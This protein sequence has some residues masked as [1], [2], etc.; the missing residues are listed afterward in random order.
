M[1]YALRGSLGQSRQLC[2]V[3]RLQVERHFGDV[4]ALQG[5]C[6]GRAAAA[7]P[8]PGSKSVVPER[9]SWASERIKGKGGFE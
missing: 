3:A 7:S 9:E 1:W 6:V 8:V 5:P 4:D 2:I